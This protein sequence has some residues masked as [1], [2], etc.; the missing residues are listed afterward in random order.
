[1]PRPI[2]ARIDLAALK[3][4]LS[5][6]RRYAP[7]SKCIVVV[8]SNG[9]GHGLV[10][11][12]KTLSTADGF[13]VLSVE[14]AIML[15]NAGIGN[16]I[17]LLE[18][19]FSE[20]EVAPAMQHKLAIVIHRLDQIDMIVSAKPKTKLDILLKINTGMNR[21]GLSAETLPRA[22]SKLAH[23]EYVEKITLMTHFATADDAQGVADQLH[24]FKQLTEGLAYDRCLANSA[25]IIRYPET[26]ADWVRPGIMIYGCTPF[27]EGSAQD[28]GL[29][30][31]MTLQSEIIA[32][33]QLKQ[34]DRVGYGG[35]YAAERNMRIGIVACGYAD[36]YL[37]HAF[38]GTPILVHGKRT[39]TVGRVSMDMMYADLSDIPEAN[40]G[41]AVVLWGDELPIEEVAKAVGTVNYELLCALATRVPMIEING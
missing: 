37:R 18:G 11:V 27:A 23:S 32:V 40:I 31:A 22:L 30:P 28:L 26:H 8:K 10:R 14:E 16:R 20:N 4:N 6:V 1:M 13:A 38:T 39:R 35:V 34:G 19:L 29:K 21:L 41:S 12:A 25:A 7:H 24:M 15:R 9:Y 5:V 3:H 17:V 2:V 33:Q 36:G